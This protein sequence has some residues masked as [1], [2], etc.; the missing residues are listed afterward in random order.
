MTNPE[1]TD[2]ESERNTDSKKILDSP[3]P[4]RVVLAGP[5]TG[6]SFLFEQAIKKKK[7][8]GGQSFLA[9]TFI[10]KLSDELSDDLAGL[11]KTTTL[12]GF[13]RSFVL[14]NCPDGWRYYPRIKDVIADDLATQGITSFNIADTAYEERTKYYTTIGDDDVVHYAVQ[15]C[16]NDESRIPKFDLVLVDEFQDF[17]DAEAEFIDI[18]ATVNDVLIVGD[19]D[20][21]LY[22]FKGSFSKF[23]KEKFD[24]SNGDF[25]SHTLTYCSR[26]TDVIIKA[27]HEVVE[28]FHSRK[29]L[30]D[31]IKKDYKFYPPEKG[32]DSECNRKLVVLEDVAPGAL[33]TKIRYE[34]SRILE[35]QKIKSVMVLGEGRTCKFLLDVT[36]KRLREVGF[37][38]VEHSKLQDSPFAFKQ[39]VIS[40]YK[41][42]SK[43]PVD[44]LGW[45]LLLYEIDDESQ[46]SKIISKHYSDNS[47]VVASVPEGFRKLA[48]K[49]S[50]TLGSIL[51]K[52]ESG[53]K[54]IADS[55]IESLSKSIV[56]NEKERREVLINQ[57]IKENRHLPRP[58]SNLSITVCNI[59][60][61]KGLSADV[62]FLIGF[63]QG[64]L[65]MKAD[66]EDSEIYQLLVAL[67]RAKKRI[68]LINTKGNHVSKFLECFGE[69]LLQRS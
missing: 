11:A 66:I 4:R 57:L 18:I 67:T 20:Q 58:L 45:R 63:D 51:S 1:K 10:G 40:G 12:H 39:H 42:L 23:I 17:N 52:P 44:V 36:A 46:R 21:A 35:E 34:L 13:A 56:A 32:A 2:H 19:D 69:G 7:K 61:S 48:Q 33:P 38:D 26:C 68:Y 28:H 60:G 53:R 55:S 64:K 50:A 37:R 54:K 31:R 65:P 62:V 9:I 24:A 27:F 47:G 6:K 41:Y 43:D 49:N 59:L 30:T 22:E 8:D 3:H 29:K 15:I 14:D 16:K 5:G 25:E